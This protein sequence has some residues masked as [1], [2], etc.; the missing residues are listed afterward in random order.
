[1]EAFDAVP[2]PSR[3]SS[4]YSKDAVIRFPRFDE[5]GFLLPMHHHADEHDAALTHD[6]ALRIL[7]AFGE[8][9][10]VDPSKV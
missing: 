3:Y 6:E 5:T 1:M 10:V 8:D 2:S 9:F 7:S 4:I